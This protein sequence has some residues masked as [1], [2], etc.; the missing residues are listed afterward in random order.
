MHSSIKKSLRLLRCSRPTTAAEFQSLLNDALTPSSEKK[1]QF[2]S[3]T[4][5]TEPV[6]VCVCVHACVLDFF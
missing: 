5:V 6:C 1:E 3:A 4:R 2:P